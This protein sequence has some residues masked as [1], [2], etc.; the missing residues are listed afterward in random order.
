MEDWQEWQV[1][2]DQ[3]AADLGTDVDGLEGTF[4]S[5]AEFNYRA[6]W[7]RFRDLKERVRTA[8]A[9]RLEPKLDLERRLRAIGS[10]A[11]KAQEVAYAR[12]GD[13]KNEI[14]E[15]IARLRMSAGEEATPR[16][17]RMLRRDFDRMRDE[18]DAGTTL[19]PPDR[20]SV[21][22]AWREANHFAWQRL[23]EMWDRNE[24]KLR[25][26]LSTARE[27]IE[28]GNSGAVRQT[29][30]NFF[31][32]LKTHEAKQDAVNAMKAEV[33][34]IRGEA[35]KIEERPSNA[36]AV[37]QRV[38]ATPAVDTWRS[39]LDRHRELSARIAREV[40][41]LE[42]EVRTSGSILEQAMLRGT[43]VD[44]KRKLAELHRSSRTLE[45]RIEQT[46]E[47]PLIPTA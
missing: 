4:F 37:Q 8:P 1:R 29:L 42:D 30:G 43:L 5:G 22:D 34:Q 25:H 17:L 36:K 20:Q 32:T 33:D 18:F 35:E 19:V 10:R 39:D 27:H 38:P 31:D 13:R 15:K 11:Y 28:R 46:E 2:A 26:I 14:L 6:F 16:G 40:A 41:T 9:I 3:I 44:K 7:P 24:E 12:S 21:W 23:V 45:Q 47:S